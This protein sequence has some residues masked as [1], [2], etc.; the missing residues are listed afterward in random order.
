[1][2]VVK[3][4][5][6]AD[7]E[8][9]E[10]GAPRSIRDFY[11]GDAS[12]SLAVLLDISGSMAVGGNMDRARQAVRLALG[13]LQSGRD[14]AALYTFDNELQEIREFTSDLQRLTSVTLEGKPWG[15]TSLYDAIDLT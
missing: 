12:I 10:G 6:R 15:K 13:Q 8:V 1:G 11:T 9:L 2:R 14:E 7:F 4:L 3:D 5:K